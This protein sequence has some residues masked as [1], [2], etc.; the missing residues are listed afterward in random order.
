MQFET[1]VPT[2]QA[3][4]PIILLSGIEGS[5]K[6]WAAAEA[7]GLAMFGRTLFLEVGEQM[8]NEYIGVPGADYEMIV[9]DGTERQVRQAVEWAAA[10]PIVDGRPSLLIVDSMTEIWS[11]LQDEQQRIANERAK[12]KGKGSNT[13]A[14]ITMDQW[15]VAKDRMNDILQSIRRFPGPA[16]LTARLDNVSVVEGGQPTGE[17]VWKIRA[18]KNLPYQATVVMQAREP[19]K[20]TMTKIASSKFQMDPRGFYQWPDFTVEELLVRMEVEPGNMIESTFVRPTANEAGQPQEPTQVMAP[21][22]GMAVGDLP[23]DLVNVLAEHEKA[24]NRDAVRDLYMVALAQS[25]EGMQGAR[26]ALARIEGAG[27]RIKKALENAPAATDTAEPVD[28]AQSQ[29]AMLDAAQEA[30]LAA[31]DDQE[32][33]LPLPED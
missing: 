19:R 9:H 2:G 32:P 6:T 25:K 10:Q 7:S 3:S 21:G 31:K 12:R 17:R 15:N 30:E 33:A 23:A 16:V 22:T 29:D 26:A 20:W 13:D 27:K 1:V 11:L 18:E 28:D 14:T 4:W 24:L 8:G 5:G